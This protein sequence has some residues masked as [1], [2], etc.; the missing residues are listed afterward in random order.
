MKPWIADFFCGAGGLTKG[1][2]RAGFSVVGVDHHPMPNYC[3]EHFIQMDA[4]EA[5]TTLVA[6]DVLPCDGGWFELEDF[7]AFHGSPPCQG[8]TVLKYRWQ[9]REYPDLIAPTRELFLKSGLPYVIENVEHAKDN[10]IDPVRICG[11]SLGLDVRRHRY[12]ETNW[13]LMAPPCAHGQQTKKFR[14]YEHGHW[15]ESPVVAMY[16]TGGGKAR[17]HWPAASGIDWMTDGELAQAVPPAYS[18]LIGYQLLA[19]IEAER[20]AVA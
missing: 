15:F 12:F 11:S 1:F 8:E 9:D 16:G 2:Q 5:L 13:P 17:E 18:E 6:G 19:H 10:L 4:L 20:R 14:K 7:A 3:G